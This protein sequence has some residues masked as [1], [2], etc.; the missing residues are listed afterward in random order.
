VALPLQ[1]PLQVQVLVTRSGWTPKLGTTKFGFQKL[2][3]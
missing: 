2:E 3:T 1:G